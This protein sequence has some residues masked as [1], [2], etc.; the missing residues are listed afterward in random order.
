V[1]HQPYRNADS[2]RGIEGFSHLWLIFGF[3]ETIDQGW[4]P[5]VRPPRLG[6][7]ERVGVFASRS[8][9]RPNG[10]G[11]SLVTLEG[12]DTTSPDGPI[13]KLGGI[14][15]IDG[16]PIYDIKPY[17]SY[18]EAIPGARAGFAHEEIPRLKV[19]IEE[20]AEND[21]KKLPTRA[22]NL[23]IEALSLDP[24]PAVQAHQEDRTFGAMLC[25]K[26]VRFTIKE[27][28]CRITDM[29]D[30]TRE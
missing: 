24:R 20:N 27:K 10:L 29:T 5:T 18:A 3:H 25:G 4:K 6:G 23:I 8:T 12:I 7:N 1:F 22:Q 21:F 15:L 17:L 13:L 26:N 11:L 14:D 16:T 9:F 2:I 30:A 19:K 28:T